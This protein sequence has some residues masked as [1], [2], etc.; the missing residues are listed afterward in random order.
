MRACEEDGKMQ[1]ERE[2][3]DGLRRANRFEIRHNRLQLFRGQ[4][5]LLTLRGENK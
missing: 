3:L 4:R 5:L 2:F 1:L